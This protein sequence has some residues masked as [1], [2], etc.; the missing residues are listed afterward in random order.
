M[1]RYNWLVR[2]GHNATV[3]AD[4]DAEWARL[5]AGQRIEK[6]SGHYPKC[7]SLSVMRPTSF[8]GVYGLLWPRKLWSWNKP[9]EL[10]Y[11]GWYQT[12][13]ATVTLPT[14]ARALS[15]SFPAL[16][17]SFGLGWNLDVIADEFK[18]NRTQVK[19]L[20]ETFEIMTIN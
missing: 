4:L 12:Q 9:C 13:L 18:L 16:M 17:T 3:K 19:Q 10:T 20:H 11:G 2:E 14:A 1:R 6:W 7:T 15:V 5:V 8:P